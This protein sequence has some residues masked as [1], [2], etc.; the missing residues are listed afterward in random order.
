[1]I[2]ITLYFIAFLVWLA[3]AVMFWIGLTDLPKSERA[4]MDWLIFGVWPISIPSLLLYDLAVY[5]RRRWAVGKVTGRN[6]N[7]G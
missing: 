2:A 4:A 6:R 5:F 3:V 1:M 7:R